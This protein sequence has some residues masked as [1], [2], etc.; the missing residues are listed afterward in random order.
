VSLSKKQREQLKQKFGG[1]CAYCGIPLGSRW[2]ADHVKPLQR[3]TRYDHAKRQYVP[4]GQMHHPERDTLD[5][6]MPACIACNND[7]SSSSLESWRSRLQD[8]PA[9]LQRNY[10]AWRHA[11]RFGL[12]QKVEK[13]VL[14]H[15]ETYKPPR[16]RKELKP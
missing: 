13:R 9:L 3:I 6:L 4:T 10:S 11:E 5:N 7:K 15:F 1:C 14:F 16:P 2:Q 12:V 8:L